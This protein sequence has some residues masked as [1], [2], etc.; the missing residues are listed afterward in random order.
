MWWRGCGDIWRRCTRCRMPDIRSATGYMRPFV[1]LGQAYG[2]ERGGQ[3]ALRDGAGRRLRKLADTTS[4]SDLLSRRPFGV[5]FSHTLQ[6]RSIWFVLGSGLT[7]TLL[8]GRR[9]VDWGMRFFWPTKRVVQSQP[10]K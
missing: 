2:S 9:R 10:W 3:I 5:V 8:G 4:S 1:M 7:W 6:L